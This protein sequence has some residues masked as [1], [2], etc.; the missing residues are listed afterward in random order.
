MVDAVAR[1]DDT[2]RP[3]H[4]PHLAQRG[5]GAGEV[6]QHLVRM[7][8]IERRVGVVERVD[9]ADRERHV[10]EAGFVR[11]GGRFRD[12]VGRRVDAEH[13]CRGEASRHVES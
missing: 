8:D 12:D 9:V 7:H 3:A 10:A 5:H 4:P 1:G 2:F 6:L 11:G 13:R